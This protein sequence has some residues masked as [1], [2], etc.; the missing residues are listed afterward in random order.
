MINFDKLTRPTS[1]SAPLDPVEIFKRTPN[2]KDAPNDLWKGQA[3][4]LARWH[5]NR[6]A[7]DNAIIL[8]TGAGKSL[9]GILVAQSLVN[10]QIGPVVFACSTIDLVSQTSRECDRIGIKYSTRIQKEFSNDLFETGRAFCITTYQALFASISTFKGQNAPKCLIFDDAHVAERLIRDSFTLSISKH[11]FPDLFDK[12]TQIVRPEFQALG[13]GAHLSYILS[14]VG[15]QSVTLCPLATSHRCREQ[16]I[17]ALKDA[18]Y[19]ASS[20]FFPTV[21]LYEHLHYCA[22]FVSSTHIEITPPFI[23]TGV[24]P[25]LGEGVRRVYLSATLEYE[26]DFVRGFGRKIPNP[27]VPDND[28]GN[29]E[30]LVLLASDFDEKSTKLSVAKSILAKRKLLISVPSYTRPKPGKKLQ[31]LLIRPHS[32]SN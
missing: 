13:K 17:Q 28:A 3:E 5:N 19:K 7:S 27:I 21:Q 26:T 9:V 22:I 12:I 1:T 10:E 15:Q 18:N 6:D 11:K 25:F 30:R 23:P 16:I 2:L 31:R 24:F 32:A 29:G 4:A 14:E 8:N 20:L